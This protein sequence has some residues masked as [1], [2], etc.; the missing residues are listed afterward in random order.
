MKARIN[1]N[2]REMADGTT[3]AMIAQAE[4]LP[5]KGVAIAVNG[6]IVQRSAWNEHVINNGDDIII[7]KAFCGG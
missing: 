2:E 3:I 4:G 1:N 7:L 5:D 6:E